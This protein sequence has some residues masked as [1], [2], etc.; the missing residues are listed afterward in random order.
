MYISTYRKSLVG[1]LRGLLFGKQ[2]QVLV[3]D[4][5]VILIVSA[6]YRAFSGV[7]SR[8]SNSA[9]QQADAL[10]SEPRRKSCK[11]VLH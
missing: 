6:R 11:S 7:P 1:Y 2:K 9:V 10:L 3:D 4:H 5:F 8:D